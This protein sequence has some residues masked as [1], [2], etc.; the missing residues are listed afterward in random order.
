MNI[1]VRFVRFYCNEGS[2]GY[3]ISVGSFG[4]KIAVVTAI[5]ITPTNCPF[6]NCYRDTVGRSNI[7]CLTLTN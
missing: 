4:P 1:L 6:T 5:T 7:T 2:D 3:N